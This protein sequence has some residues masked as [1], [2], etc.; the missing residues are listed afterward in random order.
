MGIKKGYQIRYFG[1]GY[2]LLLYEESSVTWFVGKQILNSCVK[3]L[4]EKPN[5]QIPY[6]GDQ[7][8]SHKNPA[9]Q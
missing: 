9:I 7:R 4:Y 8:P 3:S 6:A 5:S 2:L 1:N